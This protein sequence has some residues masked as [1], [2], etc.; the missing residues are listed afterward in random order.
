[1]SKV[2]SR[3]DIERLKQWANSENIPGGQQLSS[4]SP[5][6]TAKQIEEIQKQAQ[7][8]GYEAGYQEGLTGAEN[9][10]KQKV[11]RLEQIF[12]TL[13]Q[14]LEQ[15]DDAVEEQLAS[16]AL[17]IAKQIIRRELK[18]E[19]EHVIGAVREAVGVL[20]LASRNI[21][22]LLHPEDAQVVRNHLSVSESE[23][24]WK[25]VDNPTVTRGGCRI[26]TD[27]STVDATLERR[28]AAIAAELLGGERASDLSG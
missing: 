24:G 11:T 26:V 20:P 15:L 18:T 23:E 19:P 10:I 12:R 1:M 6:L 28:L 21:Q 27:T 14:P 25:I 2:I 7:K 13:Q 4:P 5:L 8:E 9:E 3:D 22:I 16:L 17:V